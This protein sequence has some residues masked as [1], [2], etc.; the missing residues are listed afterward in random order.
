MIS[1]L[2]YFLIYKLFK[3]QSE[4]NFESGRFFE[5]FQSLNL[6]RKLNL[7]RQ[8]VR[9]PHES[10]DPSFTADIVRLQNIVRKQ[11]FVYAAIQNALEKRKN[12]KVYSRNIRIFLRIWKKSLAL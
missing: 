11:K 1:E 12:L 4:L 8:F 3:I 7:Y 10:E 6:L 9:I 5:G 2:K